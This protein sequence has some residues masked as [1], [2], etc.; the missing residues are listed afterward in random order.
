LNSSTKEPLRL[1]KGDERVVL[2]PLLD[3]DGIKDQL[4]LFLYRPPKSV[5]W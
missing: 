5:A 2:R 4:W 3:T 1:G